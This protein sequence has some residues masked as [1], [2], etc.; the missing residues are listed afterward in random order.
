[1]AHR[2]MFKTVHLHA[3]CLKKEV[4][5]VTSLLNGFSIK[6][7]VDVLVSGTVVVKVRLTY[8]QILKKLTYKWG[9]Y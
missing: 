7:T 2:W 3:H 1:M 6:H 8:I 4:P 5:V 9:N